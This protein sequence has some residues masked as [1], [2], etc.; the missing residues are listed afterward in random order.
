MATEVKYK[1]QISSQDCF[2]YIESLYLGRKKE[3][4]KERTVLI[5]S[6]SSILVSSLDVPS[7]K[8]SLINYQHLSMLPI[9]AL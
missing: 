9:G 6:M 5:R 7:E 8:P 3:G 2:I 4:R 1:Y